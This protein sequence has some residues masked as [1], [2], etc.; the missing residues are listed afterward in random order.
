M[1]IEEGRRK[2]EEGRRKKELRGASR[3]GKYIRSRGEAFRQI[4]YWLKGGIYYRNASP[5]QIRICFD[6]YNMG[7]NML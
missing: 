3:I 7:M 4:S 6:C 5:L 1:G 2:K